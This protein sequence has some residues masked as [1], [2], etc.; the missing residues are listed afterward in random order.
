MKPNK[1]LYR[2]DCYNDEG[3]EISYYI[4]AID[5]IT[6]IRVFIN[7]VDRPIL[8]ITFISNLILGVEDE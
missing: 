8:A 3:L 4:A 7:K 1:C 5:I 6:A 2:I